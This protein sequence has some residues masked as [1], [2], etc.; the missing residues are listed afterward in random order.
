MRKSAGVMEHYK[1]SNSKCQITNKSQIPRLK[2]P[3]VPLKRDRELQSTKKWNGASSRF[4]KLIEKKWWE[5]VCVWW[6]GWGG[7]LLPKLQLFLDPWKRQ[8]ERTL[9]LPAIHYVLRCCWAPKDT[10]KKPVQLWV[11]HPPRYERVWVRSR[12]GNLPLEFL[13]NISKSWIQER[14]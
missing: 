11:G 4:L 14:P 5:W 3:S 1:M 12:V 7:A 2:L 10:K 13:T 9:L 8:K 6:F